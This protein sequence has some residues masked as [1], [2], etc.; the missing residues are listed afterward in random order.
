MAINPGMYSS[1]SDDW[2]TPQQL[3]DLLNDEFH[4]TLDVCASP[5]NAKCATF[6]TREED[7]LAQPW[8]GRCWMNPPYGRQ[9]LLWVRKAY[10]ESLCGTLV[11]GLLPA[12]TDT[13]WWNDY[14]TQGEIRFLRKRLRF[15]GARSSAPFPTAIVIFRNRWW[16]KGLQP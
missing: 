12:R 15:G 2:S 16:E 14:C 13:A 3:F 10:E 7:G 4:F 9:I 1:A 6:F 8:T 11:V 5:H